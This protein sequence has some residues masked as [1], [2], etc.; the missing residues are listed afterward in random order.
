MIN[1]RYHI[2]SIVAVFLALGIGLALG[3]TFV[4]SILVSNLERQVNQLEG[5]ANEAIALRSEMEGELAVA[6][7]EQS[8]FEALA[9]PLLGDS[10]LEGVPVMIVAPD[11]VERDHVERVRD[12]IVASEA[13]YTGILWLTQR[14]DLTSASARSE[15][16][17]LFSLAGNSERAVTQSLMFLMSQA[18]FDPAN[19]ALVTDSTDSNALTVLR[20]ANYMAY[21]PTFA[22]TSSLRVLPLEGTVY[23]IVTDRIAE[24]QNSMLLAPLLERF[25]SDGRSRS[26]GVAEFGFSVSLI[27]IVRKDSD[28]RQSVS[29]VDG[30]DT[31]AGLMAL[32][33]A[34]DDLPQTGHY[35]ARDG[36]D[37]LLPS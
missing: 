21:E 17:N 9:E 11:S 10:R 23:V 32:M 4:D 30:V 15:L 24:D 29:T 5:S 36:A 18:M 27:D 13:Q 8:A 19:A 25:M 16:A 28:L 7:E 20:D 33:V 6:S 37:S 14:L 3:S 12:A 35:G 1:L 22:T 34:L 26:V 2:V 31:F